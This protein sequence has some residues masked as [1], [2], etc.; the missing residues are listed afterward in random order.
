MPF[1]AKVR[2][3]VLVAG[4][5]RC[6]VCKR[7]A[8]VK[9][10]VHHIIQEAKGGDNSFDN[11]IPLCFDC[12]ADAG[13]YNPS[14]PKGTKFSPSELRR[15]R[16]ELYRLAKEAQILAVVDPELLYSRHIICR[17]ADAITEIVQDDP[18]RIPVTSAR[19]WQND[20]LEFVR[21][22]HPGRA[23]RT[24]AAEYAT[25]DDVRRAHPSLEFEAQ[26]HGRVV[27]IPLDGGVAQG[28]LTNR[29]ALTVSLLRD[30]VPVTELV[31][32]YL[33]F[34]QCGQDAYFHIL[35][36]RPLWLGMI[37][38]E[39]ATGSPITVS[40]FEGFVHRAAGLS[41]RA[42][43]QN[44]DEQNVA[45]PPVRLEPGSNLIMPEV[46]LLGPLSSSG[47][48]ADRENEEDFDRARVQVLAHGA[49]RGPAVTEIRQIGPSISVDRFTV[50]T[51]QGRVHAAIH[52]LDLSNVYV[53]NRHWMIGSC[54]HLFARTADGRWTHLGH[55]LA[56]SE[57]GTQTIVTRN[58]PVGCDLIRIWELEFETTRLES[59]QSDGRERLDAPHVLHRG[60]WIEFTCNESARTVQI[61]GSYKPSNMEIGISERVDSLADDALAALTTP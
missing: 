31:D 11:A 8:G 46:A 27:A 43:S 18:S 36:T 12:H 13:H 53:L 7:F 22:I 33:F 19:I 16:D 29:D 6:A 42:P 17:D 3:D 52:E 23:L 26:G 51:S 60:E 61:A 24:F 56:T 25:S 10:E 41:F 35:D 20:I 37:A 58:L 45:L 14:H 32:S 9:V 40:G 59:V 55:I 15:H 30:G 2:E 47:F 34:N 1:S 39:N 57:P 49:F 48:S 21:R 54:P 50:T 28:I 44:G 38:V 5:R 4:A